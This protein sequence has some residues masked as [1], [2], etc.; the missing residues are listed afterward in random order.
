MRW[1]TEEV[2][3]PEGCYYV[4]GDN[5]NDS[6]DSRS[7][8]ADRQGRVYRQGAIRAVA[9]RGTST[10]SMLAAEFGGEQKGDK[11]GICW[12]ATQGAH[13]SN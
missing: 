3:V 12:S 13:R 9:A 5:R 7:I 4:M 6:M 11:D 8:G 2:I 1:D 10:R